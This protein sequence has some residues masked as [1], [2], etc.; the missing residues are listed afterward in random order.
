MSATDAQVRIESGV[1]TAAA[2]ADADVELV[3]ALQAGTASERGQER[4]FKR[5][6]PRVLGA[7]RRRGFAP[8]DAEDLAQDT[9][10]QAFDN[11]HSLR[12]PERFGGWLFSISVN[13]FR[14]ELRRRSRH[15]TDA[16]ALSL[17]A[18]VEEGAG[19]LTL[20]DDAPQPDAGLLDQERRQLL[21]RAVAELPPQMRQ[22]VKLR[23]EQG[24]KYREVAAVMKISIE[25]VKAHLSQ[26]RKRLTAELGNPVRAGDRE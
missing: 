12:R 26:A 7:F 25:T 24:L 18:I 8:E 4:L 2:T 17:D 11:L 21:R 14:N 1:P 9:L 5:F 13:V 22:C 16:A 15:R 23:F 10:V 6:Y 20:D 19:K 3:R